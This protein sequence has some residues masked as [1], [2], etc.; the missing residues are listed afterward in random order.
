MAQ[1][2]DQAIAFKITNLP[3]ITRAF[4]KAPQLM[5]QELNTAIK[6]SLFTVHRKS[7]INTPVDTGRLRASTKSK[8]SNLQ[9]EV[10]THTNYDYYVHWGTR[11]QSA[12]PYLLT[13][14]EDSHED[15]EKFFI[16]AVDNVL[17]KIGKAT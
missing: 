13:A 16:K 12:Q 14:I 17:N 10:G 7:V 1:T 2:S 15:V 6:K 5:T 4:N 9:G 3:Q 11:Y 8:F